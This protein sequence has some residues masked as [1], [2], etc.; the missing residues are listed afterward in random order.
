M[1]SN[2]VVVGMSGGV[3]SFV[4]ALLLRQQGYDVLGIKLELWGDRDAHELTEL[5]RSL[6]IELLHYDGKELF[7][8][9]VVDSFIKGY[10]A[11]STPN[12][13]AV[14]NNEIK[15][16]LLCRAADEQGIHYIATGHYVR[17]LSQD[18][19]Y[20]VYKGI[21]PNK[22]QSYF[23]WGL[24]QE[25]LSRALTPLGV[26]TK[27]QVKAIAVNNGYI[28]I[29]KKRESM[30][31]CFLDGKD[32]RTFIRDYSGKSIQEK[33][34]NIVDASGLVIGQ[35]SG[36]LNYTIGQKRDIP[37]CNGQPLYVA[38]FDTLTNTIIA[39]TKTNLH[40]LEFRLGQVNLVRR[41]EL[42]AADIEVKV[43]GLGLNPAGYIRVLEQV[44]DTCLV[45]L[46]SPAWAVASGQ[47][48]AFYRGD[49]IIGGGI[50]C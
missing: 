10:V 45:K 5:C 37:F 8:Q 32:Y 33:P 47:P 35:H 21:D 41:E 24:K 2:R 48:V 18:G 1:I 14:C 9:L 22:D 50:I 6:G 46:S 3:D 11:G 39:D 36:L 4:T 23:L 27:Q 31:V 40:T 34:G 44:D 15:W 28:E 13:C 19:R 42:L 16:K 12:P 25:V 20:Y 30:G 43:R 17:I 29:A 26:Y 49:K 38:A 7:R